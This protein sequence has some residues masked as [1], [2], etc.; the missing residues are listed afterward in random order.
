VLVTFVAVVVAWVF[1]RAPS[2]AAA[3][4][5][6]RGMAGLDGGGVGLRAFGAVEGASARRG[7][8]SIAVLLGVVW[9]TPSTYEWLAASAPA[10]DPVSGSRWQWQPSAAWGAAVGVL[11]AVGL[12]FMLS[13]KVEFLYFQF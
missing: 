9:L 2:L 11:A 4:A 1:F 7:L 3:F 12:Y 5:I 6:V 13:R 8:A 10:L